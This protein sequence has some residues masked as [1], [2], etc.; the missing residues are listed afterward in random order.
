MQPSFHVSKENMEKIC[1]M[2]TIKFSR[3]AVVSPPLFKH[4]TKLDLGLVHTLASTD[5]CLILPEQ[6]RF[7]ARNTLVHKTSKLGLWR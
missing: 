2:A 3:P 1:F 4:E 7:L 5:P 6:V